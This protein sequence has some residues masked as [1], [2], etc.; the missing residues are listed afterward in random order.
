MRAR[1]TRVGGR[2]G[3]R[4]V[5]DTQLKL[6][7]AAL[8]HAQHAWRQLTADR[9]D[10]PAR[11]GVRAEYEDGGVADEDVV[12]VDQHRQVRVGIRGRCCAQDVASTAAARQREEEE[13]KS[14]QIRK[15]RSNSTS[16]ANARMERGSWC[17]SACHAGCSSSDLC[18]LWSIRAPPFTTHSSGVSK[19]PQE[20]G[21]ARAQISRCPSLCH[22]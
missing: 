5:D 2:A 18:A 12:Q 3:H 7:A 11:F 15:C 20:E 9:L 6:R 14:H 4:R 10:G 19:L 8:R 16:S 22:L 21:P 13:E 17:F 1:V